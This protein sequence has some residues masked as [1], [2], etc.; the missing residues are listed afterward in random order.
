MLVLH[1]SSPGTDGNMDLYI[2]LQSLLVSIHP[3]HL[4]T[5][6]SVLA[7]FHPEILARGGKMMYEA[8]QGGQCIV[9]PHHNIFF[10]NSKGVEKN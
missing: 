9:G 7:V 10:L 3:S 6:G 4:D 8:N 2:L 1:S 5:S